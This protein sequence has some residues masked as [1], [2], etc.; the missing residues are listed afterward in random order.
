M[1]PI[2][3]RRTRVAA[4]LS[5][6]TVALT[7]A[8]TTGHPDRYGTTSHAMTRSTWELSQ[9]HEGPYGKAWE[10]DRWKCFTD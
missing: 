4:L 1:H 5:V 7:C 6:G 8:V 10:A 2:L 3:S 9:A